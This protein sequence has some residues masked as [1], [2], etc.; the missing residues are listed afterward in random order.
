MDKSPTSFDGSIPERYDPYL[1]PMLFDPYAEDI[2]SRLSKESTNDQV[3]ELA[4]GTGRVSK[5]LRN[6]LPGYAKLFCTD[7]NPD[8]LHFAKT[9]HPQE[10]IHW[11][12][13][14]AQDIPFP[15][16]NFDTVVCQFGFMFM[17][18]KAKAFSEAFRVLKKGGRFYFNT[19]DKLAN[20]DAFYLANEVVSSFFPN[21][22]PVFYQIP[23][24]LFKEEE[25]YALTH[26]AGFSE[27]KIELIK[28]ELCSPSAKDAS[29]GI[30]EGNPI[31]TFINAHNSSLLEPIRSSVEKELENKFGNHPL[32]APMQAWVIEAIKA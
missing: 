30:V 29:M 5:V 13:A 1:G 11:Q 18:D 26:N 24:S 14:D 19:W 17:P 6:S 12:V 21:N 3:L 9:H 10:D 15:E 8:M 28:K 16:N 31:Y 23:F 20:N 27:T 32:K 4:C 25:I 22:P 7:L 2:V